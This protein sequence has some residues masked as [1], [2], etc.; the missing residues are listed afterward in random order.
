[1]SRQRLRELGYSSSADN[2]IVCCNVRRPDERTA[3]IE[4]RF[5]HDTKANRALL[6]RL[7]AAADSPRAIVGKLGCD[8]VLLFRVGDIEPAL[9]SIDRSGRGVFEL[10]TEGG[11]RFTIRMSG[12]DDV[13]LVGGL[14]WKNRSPLDVP[15]D[16]LAVLYSDIVESC[17]NFAFR[18]LNCSPAPTA[19]DLAR[20]QDRAARIARLQADMA[21]HPERYTR[22]AQDAAADEELVKAN[23]DATAADGNIGMLVMQARGR[24]AMRRARAA[25]NDDAARRA[26]LIG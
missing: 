12:G 1:M 4:I 7:I 5:E 8:A 24:I 20:E 22:E 26:A 15:R 13:L 25:G 10:I 23:P 6:D 9:G 21:A 3:Y 19:E 16:S 2:V 18:Q 17:V 14:S 11:E